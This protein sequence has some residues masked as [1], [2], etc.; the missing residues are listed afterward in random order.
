MGSESTEPTSVEGDL[1]AALKSHQFFLVYQPTI[2][3]ET[4]A[5]AGVEALI[6]WRH[7]SRGVLSPEVFID[8]LESTGEIVPVGRWALRTASA[9]GRR[10]TIR[11]TGSMSR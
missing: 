11:A 9:H 8:E 3:L 1:K 6:R 4:N 5:F 2:D 10:G 7:P